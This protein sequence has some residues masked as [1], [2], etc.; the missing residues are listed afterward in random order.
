MTMMHYKGYE[1]V[2]EFDEEAEISMEKSSTCGTSSRFR[3]RPHT[4]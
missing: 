2:V 4:S 3:E 1:A